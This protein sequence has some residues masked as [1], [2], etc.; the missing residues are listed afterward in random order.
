MFKNT[1]NVSMKRGITRCTV[2]TAGKKNL[3]IIALAK[4]WL[5]RDPVRI[6]RSSHAMGMNL[7]KYY[8]S[9]KHVPAGSVWV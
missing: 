2:M 5:A 4:T 9:F 6:K 1:E 3:Y 7:D 8:K